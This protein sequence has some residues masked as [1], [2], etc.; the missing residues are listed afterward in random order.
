VNFVVVRFPKELARS[1]MLIP[2]AEMR[3]NNMLSRQFRTRGSGRTGVA[4]FAATIGRPGLSARGN[5][6]NTTDHTASVPDAAGFPRT[7]E[8]PK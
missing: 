5:S 3:N 7:V 8:Q 2:S 4:L 6:S 1:A